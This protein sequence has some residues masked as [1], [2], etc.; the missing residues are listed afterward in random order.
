MKKLIR[1]LG[2][3]RET[4]NLPLVLG[5]DG[6]NKVHWWVDASYGTRYGM[7]SQTGGTMSLGCGSLYSIARK[8]KLNTTSSTEAELVGVHDVM[9][10]I[11]WTRYFMLAQGLKISHNILFQDNKSAI[12]LEKNGV[13]SSS[14]S[15]RHI[16]IRYFFIKD[17]IKSGEIEVEFCPTENMIADFF[18]KPLQGKRFLHLRKIIMGEICSEK[19]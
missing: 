14:R 4:I 8:Q 13:G 16:N 12:L 9:S 15:T 17:R 19:G 2:Y 7:R 1:M 10:Q 18:T 3:M 6:S 11:V 5:M